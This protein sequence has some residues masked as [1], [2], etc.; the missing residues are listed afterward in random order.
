MSNQQYPAENLVH[1]ILSKPM[2]EII[3]SLWRNAAFPPVAYI[4]ETSGKPH[5]SQ[6]LRRATQGW[7]SVQML[8]QNH[9][10]QQHQINV[11]ASVIFAV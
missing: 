6:L 7:Q 11:G 3:N 4:P 10:E 1:C 8:D 5:S 9:L 2:T